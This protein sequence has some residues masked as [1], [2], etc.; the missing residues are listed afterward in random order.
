MDGWLNGTL[1]FSHDEAGIPVLADFSGN[2]GSNATVRF[3]YDLDLNL[4][5][6]HWEFSDGSTQTYTFQYAVTEIY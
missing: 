4:E 3:T 6:I 5:K 2:D 1:S